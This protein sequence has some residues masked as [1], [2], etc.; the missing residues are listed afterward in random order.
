MQALPWRRRA[1]RPISDPGLPEATGPAAPP[2]AASLPHQATPAP[3]LTALPPLGGSG[4]AGG[5][6]LFILPGLPQDSSSLRHC[7]PPSR[8]PRAAGEA[9]AGGGA[10]SAGQA[11]GKGRRQPGASRRAAG[12]SSADPPSAGGS[13]V[14]PEPSAGGP[15]VISEPSAGGPVLLLRPLRPRPEL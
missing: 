2:S 10:C 14:R 13:T 8:S 9:G 15:A 5:D 11:E 3:L 7:R 12:P 4:S 6:A 1:A